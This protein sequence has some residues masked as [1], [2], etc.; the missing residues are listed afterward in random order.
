MTLSQLECFMA[1]AERLN[2]TQTANDLFMAQ[3]TL[4]RS[5]S[6]LEQELGVQLFARSSRTVA[7]TPAGQAFYKECSEVIRGCR[8]MTDAARLA[9]QGFSGRITIGILQDNFDAEAVRIYR[10]MKR[11]YPQ[12]HVSFQEQNHSHLVSR[13]LSDELDAIIHFGF[14][15]ASSGQEVIPLRQ[16]QECVV[17]AADSPF[18]K[19]TTVQAEELK[20]ESFIV[21]SRLVSRPGHDFLWRTLT[22]A[23][24]VPKVVAEVDH[25]PILLMMV[26]CGIGS[27]LLMNSVT[28]AA[29]ELVRFVPLEGITPSVQS[30][31]WQ[32][33]N[34]NPSLPFLIETV[35]ALYPQMK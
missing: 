32:R 28:T 30:L 29:G 25:I 27:T 35:K 4:S 13:L 31:V 16:E 12:I 10:E 14:L 22:N 9:E 34:Q 26:A 6:A 7:L 19:R 1:L 5:I 20:D 8:R 18:A 17:V 15:E 21:M 2:F 33:R 3:T 24:F 11:R 23:G